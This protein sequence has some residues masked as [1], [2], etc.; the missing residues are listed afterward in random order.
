MNNHIGSSLRK[1][2]ANSIIAM[3]SLRFRQIFGVAVML[4]FSF[5]IS[6]AA[7]DATT[8]SDSVSSDNAELRGEVEQLKAKVDRLDSNQPQS[9]SAPAS[10]PGTNQSASNAIHFSSGYDPAVGFV[11]RSDDGQFSFH[12]GIVLQFRDTTTYRE[13]LA[14]GNGSEVPSPRYSTENG[15]SVSRMRLTFDGKFTKDVTYYFQLQDDQAPVW[16]CWM[17]TPYIT[18]TTLPSASKS[19][20]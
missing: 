7:A 11:L 18:F 3:G 2:T 5:G 14:P 13:K 9:P 1:I 10:I 20:N 16:D 15:F 8:Q 6:R 19:G 12:P 4:A 17:R